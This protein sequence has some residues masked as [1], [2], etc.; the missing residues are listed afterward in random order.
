MAEKPKLPRWL[1]PANRVIMTL[2]RRGLVLGTEH[3]LTIPG[4]KT[5]KLHS[6]PVSLLTVDGR[7]YIC[8]VGDTEWVK[9]ARAAG[10]AT[11]SQG[12]RQ[13]RVAL[14]ELPVAERGAILREF[15]I[16]LPQ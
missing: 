1:K 11:L 2:N 6:T 7:R 13:E 9:N 8:T 3:I 16:Q 4:R 10:W 15:P 14:A 5:G 12:S